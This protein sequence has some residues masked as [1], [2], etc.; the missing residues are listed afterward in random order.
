MLCVVNFYRSLSS[1]ALSQCSVCIALCSC[2]RPSAAAAAAS[3]CPPSFFSL[4]ALLPLLANTL[5]TCPFALRSAVPP[6]TTSVWPQ[7]LLVLCECV[8]VHRC[9]LLASLMP[10]CLLLQTVDAQGSLSL[11]AAGKDS[12][13]SA[14]RD[15]YATLLALACSFSL[16]SLE[17]GL[18]ASAA[19]RVLCACLTLVALHSACPM[20]ICALSQHV[21]RGTCDI[22]RRSCGSSQTWM[23]LCLFAA[24]HLPSSLLPLR[25]PLR[26]LPFPRCASPS[27]ACE[28]LQS[29]FGH[30]ALID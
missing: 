21:C 14:S 4:R 29:I 28:P 10:A 3:V 16:A 7:S 11:L 22:R 5:I 23:F 9:S 8:R 24:F 15:R 2:R 26:R 25:R 6:R 18:L 30:T 12:H 20:R 1:F 19:R 17:V 13:T 27:C